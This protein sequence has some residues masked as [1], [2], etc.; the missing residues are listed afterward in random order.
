[1]TRE[2]YIWVAMRIFGIYLLVLAVTNLPGFITGLYFVSTIWNNVDPLR[3][4]VGMESAVMLNQV[5]VKTFANRSINSI[6]KT[7]IFSVAGW[8]ML[9][10][11]GFLFSLVNGHNPL[12][13]TSAE[14]PEETGE[15]A[16][17][18]PG[19]AQDDE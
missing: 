17:S 19:A 3:G 18:G 11:G 1:M 5:L 9:C 10:R 7:L 8:Y 12:S 16:D 15:R 6:L 14:A 4:G 13:D 2:D